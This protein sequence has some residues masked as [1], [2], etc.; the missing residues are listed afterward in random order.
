MTLR[1]KFF[2]KMVN[3]W[4]PLLLNAVEAKSLGPF[5]AE[6]DRF[7][8]SQAVKGYEEKAGEWSCEGMC[9]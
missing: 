4:N 7:L 8:I 2:S 9:V 1:R 5:K 3:L 6:I